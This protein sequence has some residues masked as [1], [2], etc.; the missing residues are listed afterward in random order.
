MVEYGFV[1]VLKGASVRNE[2]SSITLVSR[3]DLHV[4]VH[5][6]RSEKTRRE[7]LEHSSEEH[8]KS[9]L[10]E[11]LPPRHPNA[12]ALPL[13]QA[14]RHDIVFKKFSFDFV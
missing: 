2:Q 12:T 7:A 1:K 14:E 10:A 11:W 13:S 4:H 5:I 9:V 3:H 6:P 8:F